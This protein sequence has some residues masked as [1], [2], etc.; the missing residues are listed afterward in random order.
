MSS[1][2][3]GKD[4]SKFFSPRSIV[5]V[6]VSRSSF[7]LGG[8]SYLS[9]LQDSRFG[10][11]LYPINPKAGEIRGIRAYPNIKSLPEVPDLAIVCVSAPQVPAVLEE[12]ASVGLRYIHILTAGFRETGTRE[13]ERLEEQ[14]AA[15]ARQRG[16]LVMGPN[17]MGPYCPSSGLTAWGARPGRDGPVGVISQSGG[18]TQRLTE[19]LCSLG[20]GVHKAASI[21]NAAV[22]DSTDY[23]DFMA[24]DEGIRVIA[25]YLESVRDGRHLLRLVKEVNSRKPIILLKGGETETGASTVASHTG[26]M[27]GQQVLWEAFIR[28]AGVTRVRSINEWADAILAFCH[29]QGPRGKGVFLVG[30]GG[31]NSVIHGDTCIREGLDVPKLSGASMARLRRIVPMAGSIAGNPLDLWVT[32]QDPA[33]LAEVLEI[34]YKDPRIHMVIVDRLIPRKAF[35]MPD[36]PDPTPETID[37]VKGNGLRKPT[38]FALDSE[39]GDEDLI[40][41]GTAVRTQFCFAG[42]PAYPSLERAAR[43]L[44]HLQ[45]YHAR[46]KSQPESP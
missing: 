27:A 32:F 44:V 17:C 20:T 1:S 31:G 35:H 30:G 2:A 8:L 14:L 24:D 29:L 11:P 43:A 46:F 45:R 10:G 38:I 41:K 34:A 39:G 21:G 42:I 7:R 16:L 36:L 9:A 4:L 28:Q 12:C 33:R 19:H 3:K 15:I 40:S 5:I 6:G 18:I 26:T 37:F 13:G 25:M 23:L 22:L